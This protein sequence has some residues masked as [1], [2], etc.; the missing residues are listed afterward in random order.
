M[1]DATY[2]EEWDLK[3]SENLPKDTSLTVVYRPGTATEVGALR[4]ASNYPKAT[5]IPTNEEHGAVPSTFLQSYF[6]SINR[7]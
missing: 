5:L 7:V 2:M 1:L 6:E 4:I 3:I